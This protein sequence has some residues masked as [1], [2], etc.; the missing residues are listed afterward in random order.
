MGGAVPV[1][2]VP[3]NDKQRG[4]RLTM[5]G[6]DKSSE[7][8][9]RVLVAI[10]TYNEI[11]NIPSLI[12]EVFL[13]LSDLDV[14]VVDDNSPDGTGRWCD[15]KS[16][17]DQRVSCLHRSGRLGLGTATIEAFQYAQREGYHWVIIMDA[18]FSHHPRYLPDLL[19]G[20]G[21]AS[22]QG[23]D[24]VIGS[25]YIAGGST[26]GWP[27]SRRLISWLVNRWTRLC[28]SL[29][30]RDC[31]GAYRCYRV[32]I[33]NEVDFSQFRSRGFS[34]QEEIL[35]RVRRLGA[36]FAEVPITFANR[37]R[38]ESKIN[39]REMCG[40]MVTLLRLGI[41]NWLGF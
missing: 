21:E 41:T 19:R 27:W 13:H 22:E 32:E 9:D 16:A 23:P 17:E 36:R 30:V 38:G 24:V 15:E 18:D 12:E 25:R 4:R 35:W 31:S 20:R 5:D 1:G 11:E 14:L 8:S 3:G 2:S 37:T 7:I 39:L 33:L 10:P 6:Q 29:P 40:S 26:T 28:L 34:F